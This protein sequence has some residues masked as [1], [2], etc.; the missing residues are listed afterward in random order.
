MK[1]VIGMLAVVALVSSVASAELLK[2]FK[3]DGKIEIN[4]YQST[5]DV[6][7]NS[8]TKDAWSD[9]QTRVQLNAGF[10]LNEDVNAVVS[11]VK[12]N[13]NYGN[14]SE[15]ATTN[16]AV[17]SA[18]DGVLGNIF[19]E[20]AYLNLKGVLG[21]DHK[22]GRQYYGNEGDLVVY[23]G[24]TA[25]PYMWYLPVSAID[26]WTGWY[27]TGKLDIQ[28]VYGKLSDSYVAP[29][30]RDVNVNGLAANY[31]LLTDLKL[32]AY[33]Y[34]KKTMNAPGTTD[35][36]LDVAGVKAT[37]KFM[38]FDYYGELAKNY[39][40]NAGIDYTG[41]AFL[42]NAK[43]GMDFMGKW[44][45]MGEFAVG[46]GEDKTTDKKDKAFHSINSDYRSGVIVGGQ[47][48][49]VGL[50]DSDASATVTDT[51]LTTWNV[52]AKWNPSKVEKLDLTAKYFFFAP[53]ETKCDGVKIGYTTVGS[54][55]DFAA[56][57]K[58]S[59]TVSVRG[60]VAAFM[61]DKKY[62]KVALASATAKN[63]AVKY[64]GLDFIVKF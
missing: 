41:T 9:V 11:V 47:M 64:A 51:G 59:E 8:K 32:G 57:W 40:S 44:T 30:D 24:P 26:A 46:S 14:N 33:M 34:E 19:F 27:K 7:F 21:I 29:T 45:F 3:Y 39:G 13:R 58:H 55:I 63:D 18:N 43:Y 31:E 10:D 60:T 28:A 48:E 20:Q 12:N 25:Y 15:S 62:A 36:T 61:P 4:G 6:D 50:A 35:T 38:G 1:K 49:L 56:N 54:E 53:T 52:G 17:G 2:N 42:A 16:T 23:Y 22:L 5:N 37:G